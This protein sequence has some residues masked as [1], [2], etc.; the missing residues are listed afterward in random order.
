MT[1]AGRVATRVKA[2]VHSVPLF[3]AILVELKKMRA[4]AKSFPGALQSAR[5]ALDTPRNHVWQDELVD[6]WQPFSA[7]Q[8]KL[9]RLSDTLDS[10]YGALVED[11]IEPPA[12]ARIDDA[13]SH[14]RFFDR[15]NMGSR[16]YIAYSERA[17]QDW[18]RSFMRWIDGSIQS[19]EQV[20]RR[21]ESN[22]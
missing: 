4:W 16:E 13:I 21:V 12:G 9:F 22:F 5:N 11:Y 2:E 18:F 14:P 20:I 6:F 15:P 17:L 3:R 7:I 1:V 19:V 8:E 10:E